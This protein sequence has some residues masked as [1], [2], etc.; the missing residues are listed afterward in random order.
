MGRRFTKP[1][2]LLK[3]Y[4][5]LKETP[6]KDVSQRTEWNVRDSDATLI[7]SFGE[8]KKSSGTAYTYRCCEKYKKPVFISKDGN[9]EEII[10]WLKR[11]GK[12]LELNVAGPRESGSPGIY[13]KTK[14]L[15]NEV[16]KYNK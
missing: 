8:I 5:Q 14:E 10:N 3:K 1:A 12:N 13:K 6:S 4:P 7:I 11:V 16:L 15:I 9:V 2:G